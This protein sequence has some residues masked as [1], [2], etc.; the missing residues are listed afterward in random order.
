MTI[1]V[2]DRNGESRYGARV[3]SPR[4][5]PPIVGIRADIIPE[6]NAVHRSVAAS[7]TRFTLRDGRKS[8][9]IILPRLFLH[10]GLSISLI[11][12]APRA[13]WARA[14]GRQ[15]RGHVYNASRFN[16]LRLLAARAV[17]SVGADVDDGTYVY[18]PFIDDNDTSRPKRIFLSR[19]GARTYKSVCR[20]HKNMY[21]GAMCSRGCD[22]RDDFH[23]TSP[24][25][26][27]AAFRVRA[28]GWIALH[29][30]RKSGSLP[31]FFLFLSHS[32]TGAPRRD[33][34]G[35][36]R[37]GIND[38]EEGEQRETYDP[39]GMILRRLCV[40]GSLKV[41]KPFRALRRLCPI[42]IM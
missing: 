26:N 17:L 31:F 25:L 18:E 27:I 12:S 37:Y 35:A 34:R 28:R 13:P 8:A 14:L 9:R 40:R 24:M 22:Y 29:C 15:R 42:V 32:G 41:Y 5:I 16:P 7:A 30:A 39:L 36:G 11:L 3:R 10:R 1:I 2:Y 23:A 38:G 33:G 6:T 20:G 4:T 19:R 21:M